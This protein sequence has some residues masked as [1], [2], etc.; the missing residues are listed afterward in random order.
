MKVLVV[1]LHDVAPSKAEL[2]RRWLDLVESRGVKASLL[3]VPGQWNGQSFESSAQFLEWL[4]AAEKRGHEIVLHGYQHLADPQFVSK[5]FRSKFGRIVGRGCEE[6]WE[7][8]L[9]EASR[10]LHLGKLAIQRVGL[11]SNGFVAPAWLMSAGTLQALHM[12]DFAHTSTHMRFVD[13]KNSRSFWMPVLSQ[14][15]Q[16]LLTRIAC[17]VNRNVTAVILRRRMPFRLAIHPNDL[18]NQ[19]VR[20]SNLDILDRAL[21]QGY[22]TRTYREMI[23]VNGTHS[24]VEVSE[25]K[26][27]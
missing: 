17:Q 3:V 9:S 26:N 20:K 11:N 27:P 10:R 4:R 19:R 16:S 8:P 21:S 24:D 18:V 13:L 1:S 22:E 14:R 2:C 7:L 5:T 6:F 23:N 12:Q 25:V 15:P